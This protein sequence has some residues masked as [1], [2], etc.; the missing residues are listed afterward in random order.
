[1]AHAQ[2]CSGGGGG[3]QK[4]KVT[5]SY[6][7]SWKPCWNTPDP[8]LNATN[9]AR[10]VVQGFRVLAVFAEDQHSVPST[11]MVAHSHL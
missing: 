4:F 1:M 3:N 10:E 8:V 9:G 2:K 7:G 6:I 5:I 11:L